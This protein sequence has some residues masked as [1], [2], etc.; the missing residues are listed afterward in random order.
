MRRRRSGT[1]AS[2]T[3][4]IGALAA[5]AVAACARRPAADRVPDS[6]G[7]APAATPDVAPGAHGPALL[8]RQGV[9]LVA[10]EER[11]ADALR[12]GDAAALD[13]L[14]APDFASVD[15]AARSARADWLA[16]QRGSAIDSSFVVNVRPTATDAS[17]EVTLDWYRRARGAAPGETL[18]LRDRWVAAGDTWRL[19][20]RTV[21]ARRTGLPVVVPNRS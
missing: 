7:V 13:G 20:Q 11:L 8:T 17:A 2:R 1:R 10:L 19:A 5:A 21:V 4:A 14:L 18:S 3:L 12:G 9:A 16:A 6:A 15:G